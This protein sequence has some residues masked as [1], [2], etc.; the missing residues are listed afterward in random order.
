MNACVFGHGSSLWSRWQPSSDHTSV[1]LL[2]HT[3]C[4]VMADTCRDRVKTLLLAW[5]PDPMATDGGGVFLW[6]GLEGERKMSGQ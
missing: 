5:Q 4:H 6:A 1:L 3:V 2:S